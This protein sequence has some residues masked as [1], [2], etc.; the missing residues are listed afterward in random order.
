MALA[1]QT[2]TPT[3]TTTLTPQPSNYCCLPAQGLANMMRWGLALVV[4]S[5]IV[6]SCSAQQ[7][8]LQ[9]QL[10]LKVLVTTPSD[11]GSEA[12]AASGLTLT[13]RQALT[14]RVSCCQG[15]P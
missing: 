2:Q 10:P 7:A 3:T 12:A 11:L 9:D 1:K 6:Q 8:F 5:I 14:V 13:G 15:Q 4:V